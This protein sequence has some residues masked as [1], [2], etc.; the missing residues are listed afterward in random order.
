MVILAGGASSRM[1]KDKS[2]LPAGGKTFLETQIEKGRLLGIEDILVSGYQGKS[3]S[4]RIIKDRIPGKGPLGGLEACFREAEN[5]WC[6]VLGVDVPMVP[7]RDLEQL[8]QRPRFSSAPA[9]ILQH[10]GR[11][12]PLIGVY[13]T[14]LADAMLAE[15][16]ERK[17]SVFAFLGRIGY[18]T[19]VSGSPDEYFS[20][21]NDPAAYEALKRSGRF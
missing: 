8:I 19:Y 4:E 2:D 9:V 15:I 7:V 1:G 18:E 6:L 20:N 3:C 11:E 21:V 16:T 12:E 17:G 5:E 13:R 10:G 14:S